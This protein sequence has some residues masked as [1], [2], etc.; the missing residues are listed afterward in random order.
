MADSADARKRAAR[1]ARAKKARVYLNEVL[2]MDPMSDAWRMVEKRWKFCGLSKQKATDKP[3]D[4]EALRKQRRYLERQLE[5]FR[6]NFWLEPGESLRRSLD[7]LSADPFP[8]LKAGVDRLKLLTLHREELQDLG[9]HPKREINLYNTLR[10]VVMLSPREAGS[11][12]EKYLREYAYSKT[13]NKI[14]RMIKIIREEYPAIYDMESDWFQQIGR[15]RNRLKE[16][17][18]SQTAGW[19]FEL[20]AW[21]WVVLVILLGRVVLAIVRYSG[22]F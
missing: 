2:S 5:D 6:G 20:P 21:M 15:I 18:V 12:K 17:T 19:S 7:E 9:Q 13:P 11:I 10:R 4:P 16:D 1:V 3:A 22:G 8:D 14:R